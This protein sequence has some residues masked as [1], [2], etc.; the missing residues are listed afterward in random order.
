MDTPKAQFANVN[1]NIL[2][3]SQLQKGK[4]HGTVDIVNAVIATEREENRSSRRIDIDTEDF[5][6]HL[7]VRFKWFY[8]QF[9]W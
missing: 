5:V 7:K 6:Y 9:C 8:F 3:N 1:S 2:S 4:I